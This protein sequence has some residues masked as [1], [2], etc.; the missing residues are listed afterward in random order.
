MY[1]PVRV[2]SSA[3]SRISPMGLSIIVA[4]AIAPLSRLLLLQVPH[5]GGRRVAVGGGGRFLAVELGPGTALAL[6][7]A[8]S[9]FGAIDH[10][11]AGAAEGGDV[12]A[13]QIPAGR[14][15]QHLSVGTRLRGF[16]HA[17]EVE[18]E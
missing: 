4:A 10:G 11:Q 9:R 1:K 17:A 13:G 8:P 3:V 12:V 18:R 7:D 15:Q 16:G 5:D 6:D 2:P 14:H